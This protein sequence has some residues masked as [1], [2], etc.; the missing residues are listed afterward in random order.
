LLSKTRKNQNAYRTKIVKMTS[1][2]LII[3]GGWLTFGSSEAIGW[4]HVSLAGEI[5]MLVGYAIWI[6]IKT[7][8]GE[9]PRS[10]LSKQL[11]KI[12]F[13]D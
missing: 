3:V 9:D 8:Q 5:M 6:A 13:V 4:F 1:F 10:A 11:N 2:V 12:V 7:Y